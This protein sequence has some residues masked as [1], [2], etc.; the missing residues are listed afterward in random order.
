MGGKL[1]ILAR[2]YHL[3]G[4]NFDDTAIFD[5]DFSDGL[6]HD[7][8]LG[9]EAK[10]E[11]SVF[12]GTFIGGGSLRCMV[13]NC[14]F[15]W[16][17]FDTVCANNATFYGCVFKGV[18]F[19]KCSMRGISFLNCSFLNCT[20]ESCD[21][22]YANMR[23]TGFTA[24]RFLD[25]D[26]YSANLP[27]TFAPRSLEY[28]KNIPY[29]PMVCPEEGEFIGYKKAWVTYSGF[30]Y[31]VI[32]TLRIPADARRSSGTGRKCRSDKAIVEK[33]EWASSGPTINP[34]IA[35][36][37][38]NYDFHYAVGRVVQPTNGFCEDR[39]KTCAGG[40]HFF[41]NKQEAIDY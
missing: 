35:H 21:F 7:C 25:C 29:I 5:S 37:I 26:F 8:H 24:T 4:L 13:T 1:K 36:S 15:D 38:H 18:D 31:Y 16:S 17:T 3:R 23:D 22:S 34:S 27:E 41:M 19:T 20:F 32:I 39:W 14:I 10:L 12:I 33:M 6:L 28:C 30:K 40:I 9:V 2:R 11:N